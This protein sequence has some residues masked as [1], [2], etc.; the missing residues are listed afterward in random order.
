[1]TS[2][3]LPGVPTQIPVSFAVVDVPPVKMPWKAMMPVLLCM[4]FAVL[5]PLNTASVPGA[6][7]PLR[8][9]ITGGLATESK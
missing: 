2:W 1:M 4:K 9:T 7:S 5:T 6:A 8:S 3:K